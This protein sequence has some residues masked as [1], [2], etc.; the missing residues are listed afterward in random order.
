MGRRASSGDVLRA[1][2]LAVTISGLWCVVSGRTNLDAW[3]VPVDYRGDS[4]FT[5]AT[6]KAARDGHVVPLAT[7]EVPELN[8]PYGASWNDFLRQ[9]KLQYWLAGRLARACGLF[10]ASNLLLLLA[11][12]LAGWSFYA[13]ARYFRSRPE[14]AFAGA[15]TFAL[16]PFFFYRSL[17]HLTLSFDWPIPPAILVV[18]W[19]FGRSGLRLGSRRLWVAMAIVFVTGLHNIYYAGLLAQFL[20][21]ASLAPLVSRRAPGAALAP[22]ILLGVLVASVVADNANVIAYGA[23][24]GPT[25]DKLLRPYGNL[26]RYALKPIELLL[27]AGGSGGLFPFPSLAAAYYQGALYRGEMGSAYLGLGGIAALASLVLAAVRSHLLRSSGR[28]PAAFL[29][30]AWILV[31]SVVGGLNGVLGALGFV[32]FRA[33]NRHSIWILALILLWGA[34]RVS[35]ARWTRRRGVS[36]LASGL[37]AALALGDQLPPRTPT[38]EIESV[39]AVI[40][41]DATLSRMLE[42]ALPPGAMLFQLPVADFPEGPRIGSAIDYEH[43]RPYLFTSRLRFS[44]GSDKGRAREAWQHRMEELPPETMVDALERC[45]F[46]GILLNRKAYADGGQGLRERLA[47]SGRPEAWESPDREFLFVRLRPATNPAPPDE[48]VLKAAPPPAP[49]D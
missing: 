21:L 29:A 12:V 32:W 23:R 26:E 18:T 17:P 4:W 46:A 19:C 3:R 7:L 28:V 1:A 15:C 5:L 43:L 20:G 44:Y 9:H 49:T 45:G 40:A 36:L 37:A 16:S 34:G 10:A 13:V 33:T 24:H 8:A 42:A 11:A 47:A 2:A 25:L 48:V 30:V 27:P 31:G 22:L 38:S 35:R 6:L 14:W 41:S 39:R